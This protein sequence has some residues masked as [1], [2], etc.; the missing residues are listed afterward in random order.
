MSFQA[1]L[2]PVKDKTNRGPTDAGPF[3]PVLVV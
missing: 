2:D 3:G 1:H